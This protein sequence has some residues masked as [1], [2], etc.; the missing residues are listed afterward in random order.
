MIHAQ[1]ILRED[2]A[3]DTRQSFSIMLD[4]H[5]KALKWLK[6]TAV[7]LKKQGTD[8]LLLSELDDV[9]QNMVTDGRR[10]RRVKNKLGV[11]EPRI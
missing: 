9:H 4:S 1:D 10:L 11:S 6:A 5:T 8:P 2:L 7:R 3:R